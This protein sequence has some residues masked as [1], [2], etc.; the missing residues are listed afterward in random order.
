MDAGE[1]ETIT[2]SFTETAG[3]S[4]HINS[5]THQFY[6]QSGTQIS[7]LNNPTPNDI[8]LT[9]NG[10]VTWLD[11]V[12][13][14]QEVVYNA[15]ALGEYVIILHSNFEGLSASNTPFN[16]EVD[17]T[18]IIPPGDFGKSSPSNGATGQPASPLLSWN[19]SI[20]AID[21]EFCLDTV[22]NDQCDVSWVGTYDLSAQIYGLNPSTTYYWQ[23][24]AN[25]SAGTTYADSNTWW[26]FTTSDYP[27][28]TI[29]SLTTSPESPAAYQPL[30]ISVEVANQ[31][32]VD[33]S[34]FWIDLY[35]N[36]QP[37]ECGDIGDY[38]RHVDLLAAEDTQIFSGNLNGT[39][40]DG[41]PEGTHELYAYVDVTCQLAESDE[42]N[43]GFGPITIEV[44]PP[45]PPPENDDIDSAKL[46]S[47]TPY[48]DVLDTRGATWAEDDPIIEACN[49]N[50]G[51][52]SVWYEFTPTLNG[53][54]TVDTIGSD[55][56]TVLALWSGER[57]SLIPVACNDDIGLVGDFY[58]QD[59]VITTSLTSG[60][61]YYIEVTKFGDHLV[62]EQSVR[63]TSS[64]EN[65]D[66]PGEISALSGGMLTLNV[67]FSSN[68]SPVLDPIG[69]QYDDEGE[70]ISL[71]VTASDPDL[72]D[73]EYS[74]TGLPPDLSI[75]TD[76]GVI[77]G[78]LDYVSL[79]DYAVEVTVSDGHL[80]DSE[81][82]TWHVSERV[83]ASTWY[84]AEGYSGAGFGTYIL[85][86]N[87]NADP[88]DVILTYM[89][90]GGGIVK[91]S[92]AVAGNSRT[93][94]VAHDATQVGLDQAFSTKL[95]ADR[96][97][98]VERAMYW[99]NGEG[100]SGGHVTVGLK[101]ADTVWYLAEGY[102][103]AGF[104][105]YILIQ[106]PND[107]A[108]DVDVTYMVQGDSNV[109]TS[110]S[111]PANSRYT[112]VAQDAAQVGL[113]K[114]F[115]TK[116]VADHP[117]IVE[118]AMYFAND[119]HAAVGVTNPQTNWYL[120]EGYTG[121]G[122]GTYI[123]IQNPNATPANVD[124]TYMVQGESN[125]SSSV[126]VPANSRYTV[127]AAES[128]QVGVDKAFSTEL[129]SDMPIIVERAMYWPN[130]TDMSGGHN[131][132]AVE[133]PSLIWNLAEGYTGA[134][135]ETF[136]LVQ[137]P[138]GT[139]ADVDVTYMLQGGGIATS[140]VMVPANSRTTIEAHDAGQVGLDQAFSTRL[141]SD[142]TIIV[143]RAMY[144]AN[145]GHNTTG[146]SEP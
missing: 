23:I 14:P 4:G 131:S 65:K 27:D 143:E 80:S 63:S 38:Y 100:T 10:T 73:L 64:D 81:S 128:G 88:A 120:A 129:E 141:V 49:L 137:N 30:D 20:G 54:I 106:N 136:I 117:I 15:R 9:P 47:S 95:E 142:E 145:G 19:N 99:P 105:T 66:L 6:T 121:A 86:Q 16:A 67:E 138:N 146:V 13:L 29:L 43:N 7:N 91:R 17:L 61:R 109:S 26:S 84:L 94:V 57:G 123:L 33:A 122:F 31:G 3:G 59:S 53:T 90:Q 55:Y 50:A 5:R 134:G 41:L 1:Y 35:L 127:V 75:D 102:T 68:Q 72:D 69:D 60:T 135:F 12:Y 56:D 76:T 79:G 74:A 11:N 118:R 40:H 113:D 115:S 110:V 119:G 82:F 96:S 112:I 8:T 24:R 97:I 51:K 71:A 101:Q 116:L 108:A 89:L 104:G 85:I 83:P 2:Y 58:D 130:G 111:V 125:V 37:S 25:N 34:D 93:T 48:N 70:I 36:R 140:S 87:P 45:L 126:I 144:F 42:F 32:T 133:S 77:S 103:G 124:L 18:I 22:N 132:P 21:Y 46:I 92:V 39:T 139:D 44:G 107:V 98:I 28:L 52:T 114:A 62:S 78:L